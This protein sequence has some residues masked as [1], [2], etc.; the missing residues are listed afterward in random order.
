MQTEEIIE[1]VIVLDRP[2]YSLLCTEDSVVLAITAVALALGFLAWRRLQGELLRK[3]V[4]AG[5]SGLLCYVVYY[6]GFDGFWPEP[7][8]YSVSGAIFAGGVL[9]P[10]LRYDRSVW[11]RG[12]GLIVISTL[13]YWAAIE[14]ADRTTALAFSVDTRAFLAASVVGAFIVFTGARFITPLNRSISLLVAGFSA[15]IVGGLAFALVQELDNHF[16]MSLAFLAWHSLM[17]VSIHLAEDWQL[18]IGRI[19]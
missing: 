5:A 11:Y 4:L 6:F 10:Y 2:W 18:R 14:T 7:L 15:A 12:L 9:F 19:E 16:S 8:F 1:E 13:S 3:L 17:A